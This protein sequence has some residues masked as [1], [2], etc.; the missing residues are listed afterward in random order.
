M[1]L[2]A[3]VKSAEI[4]TGFIEGDIIDIDWVGKDITV[5][6]KEESDYVES[7]ENFLVPPEAHI[8][9]KG[10]PASFSALEIGDH[11]VVQYYID[12]SGSKTLTGITVSKSINQND[13]PAQE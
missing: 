10:K 2:F 4:N 6:Y 7:Q 5:E 1:P 11:A 13:N 9:K 12:S 8:F 3:Q